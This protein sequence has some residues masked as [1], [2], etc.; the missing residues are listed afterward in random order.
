MELEIE[1]LE[2]AATW[3]V[4]FGAEP[5]NDGERQAWREWLEA[6][7]R[8]RRAWER[9]E[10]LQGQW[11]A[12]PAE[13][14][15]HTLAGVRA[16]RRAL[17]KTLALL[18]CA[19]GSGWLASGGL[20]YRALLAGERTGVGER[21]QLR[22]A[23]GTRVDLSSA[24]ALDLA[25]DESLRQAYLWRGEI[26]VESAQSA[27]SFLVHTAQGSVRALGTRF[28]VRCEG[29]RTRVCVLSH[30]VELRPLQTPTRPM[31]LPAGQQA[32]FDE[33]RGYSSTPLREGE[34]SWTQ[35]VLT[36]V[37]WPLGEFIAEL[38]RYRT[39]VLRCAAEVAELRLSGA[40]RLDRID[41]VLQNLGKS[42]PVRVRYLTR[43]WVTVE[44]V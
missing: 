33:R 5:P 3:Y 42:L 44:S 16:R 26:L 24:T 10:R 11:A 2:A 40:Y 21:R 23:D 36:V 6:D 22:L 1:V 27:R 15:L 4:R 28:S 32:L 12:L 18:A 8:H 7:P 35:G 17:L 25:Y 20:P 9:I 13:T 37:D 41:A 29:P 19:A 38:S 34:G 39:G 43:Y 31:R 14:S 30:A